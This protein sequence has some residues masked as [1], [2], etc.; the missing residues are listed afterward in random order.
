MLLRMERVE[1]LEGGF[2]GAAR[3]GHLVLVDNQGGRV[4]GGDVG[5]N[6]VAFM[7]DDEG[8]LLRLDGA[9]GVQRVAD[10]EAAADL[11]KDLG[12]TGLHPGT[13][14]CS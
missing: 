12:G 4:D 10:E 7:P 13:G 14:T 1:G 2:D 5:R 8:Q 11:V 3:S 9:G 6:E